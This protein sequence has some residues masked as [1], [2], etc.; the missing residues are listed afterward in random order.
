MTAPVALV[1][2][3]VHVLRNQECR[4]ALSVLAIMSRAV[5]GW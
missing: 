3:D 2:G 4:A 5:P 1:L